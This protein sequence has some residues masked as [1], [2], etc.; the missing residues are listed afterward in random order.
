MRLNVSV[1]SSEP[2]TVEKRS[3]SNVEYGHPVHREFVKSIGAKPLILDSDN[4]PTIFSK[5]LLQD[6]YN[7]SSF[8][9]DNSDIYITENPTA[10][11]SAPRIKHQHSDSKIIHLATKWG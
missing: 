8:Q 1:V 7:S 9:S 5:T 2:H 3:N 10:L 4:L 6:V 11:Y